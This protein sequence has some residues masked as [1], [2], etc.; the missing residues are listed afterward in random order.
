MRFIRCL[1]SAVLGAGLALATTAA[2]MHDSP[3]V[4]TVYSDYV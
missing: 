4:V 1:L 2:K 3:V